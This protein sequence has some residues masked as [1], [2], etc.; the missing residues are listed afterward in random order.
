MN[1]TNNASSLTGQ[2]YSMF[3]TISPALTASSGATDF[4][5]NWNGISGV[6]YQVLWSTNLVTWQPLGSPISG[7]NGPMQFVL[8]SGS[9]SSEFFQI[10]A[11][12]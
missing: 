1:Y 3:Q 2:N 9:N 4:S 11:G 7:T 8:P 10:Q 6:T 12:D 5:L